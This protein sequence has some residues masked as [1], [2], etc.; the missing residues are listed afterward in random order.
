MPPYVHSPQINGLQ[1]CGIMFGTNNKRRAHPR[2][3]PR[4][5]LMKLAYSSTRIVHAWPG[6][7]P[8]NIMTPNSKGKMLDSCQKP[9]IVPYPED[10][11][12]TPGCC[13][14]EKAG[15]VSSLCCDVAG[16]RGGSIL[17]TPTPRALDGL[18]Q[19]PEGVGLHR[20]ERVGLCLG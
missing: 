8:S 5:K 19:I 2:G 20:V 3:N 11:K 9:S 4:G 6:I 16:R 12:E 18:V 1:G 14:I 17:F 10:D 13:R 15:D 7:N